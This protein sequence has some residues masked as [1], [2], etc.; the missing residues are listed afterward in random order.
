MQILIL[1][2][3]SGTDL[4]FEWSFMT[5][6]KRELICQQPAM[7]QLHEVQ[8]VVSQPWGAG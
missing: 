7:P 4:K 5:T 1:F 6:A 3:R 2:L 8:E